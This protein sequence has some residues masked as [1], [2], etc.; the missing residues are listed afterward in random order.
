MTHLDPKGDGRYLISNCKDQTIKLWDM[1]N[2]MEPRQYNP[3]LIREQELAFRWYSPLPIW[4]LGQFDST[5]SGTGG[6]TTHQ[7]L[8]LGA[9]RII[10]LPLAT[11]HTPHQAAPCYHAHVPLPPCASHAPSL[12]QFVCTSHSAGAYASKLAPFPLLASLYFPRQ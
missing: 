11:M 9:I 3:K 12:P 2:M 10:K 6:N 8:A 4:H 7:Y 1:R 5:R